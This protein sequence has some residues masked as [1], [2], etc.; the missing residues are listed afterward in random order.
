MKVVLIWAA[1]K[2]FA[3]DRNE[4]VN[5]YQLVF[6]NQANGETYRHFVNKDKP[7]GFTEAMVANIKGKELEISTT[8]KTYLGKSR[9]VLESIVPVS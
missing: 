3:N 7:K 2:T 8:V 9:T 5:G 6:M 1:E 4:E